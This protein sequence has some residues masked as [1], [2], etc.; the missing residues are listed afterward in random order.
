MDIQQKIEILQ[1]HAL[2]KG[3]KPNEIKILAEKTKEKKF[4]P[5]AT[6]LNQAEPA[7]TIYFIYTGLVKIYI[8]NI[9]GKIIPIRVRESPYIVGELNLFDDESSASVET[10]L[11][12]HT[13]LIPKE[14]FIK[15]IHTQSLFSFNLLKVI[16]EKLRA[17]NNQTNYYV[18]SGL[19][20]RTWK[21]L[22]TLA[23]HFPNGEIALSQEELSFMIGASRARVSEIL[24]ELE[25]QKLITLTRRKICLL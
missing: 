13:L 12:T 20:Q 4:P 17:A 2:F 25:A 18:S 15:L 16:T 24:T 14:E 21:I 11:E 8:L 5:G 22:E 7:T 19:K 3:L 1:K 9:E 23:A 6:I 10:I